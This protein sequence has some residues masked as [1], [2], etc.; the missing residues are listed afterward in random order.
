M[1]HSLP[2]PG[3]TV[4]DVLQSLSAR[5]VIY[6]LSELQEPWGFEA[7]AMQVAKFHL[8][9]NGSCRLELDGHGPVPLAAG[10]LVLLPHGDAHTVRTSPAHQCG[11]SIRSWRQP[12][13]RGRQADIWRP[14]RYHQAAVRR[15]RPGRTSPRPARTLLPRL[16]RLDAATAGPAAWLTPF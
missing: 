16:L 3:D 1:N 8:V 7:E 10:D 2:W 13:R 5:S 12:S 9:I 11:A 4:S 6:C 14:W 15:L